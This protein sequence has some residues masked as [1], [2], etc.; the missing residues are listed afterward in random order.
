[1]KCF[2]VR[3]TKPESLSSGGW[4]IILFGDVVAPLIQQGL[5]VS[6]PGGAREGEQEHNCVISRAVL[7]EVELPA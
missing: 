7:T 5:E 1:M 3:F 4:F 2:L 6:A